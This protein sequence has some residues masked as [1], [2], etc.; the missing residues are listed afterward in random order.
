MVC[1]DPSRAASRIGY[2]YHPSGY[3]GEYLS[4]A[5]GQ[6]QQGH[7]TASLRFERVSGAPGLR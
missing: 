7:R 1:G 2:P 6:K 5:D 4:G 3:L